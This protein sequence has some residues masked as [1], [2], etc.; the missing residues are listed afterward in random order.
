MVTKD[1]E[2]DKL[3]H[4]LD[5]NDPDA[6]GTVV[7]DE[8]HSETCPCDSCAEVEARYQKLREKHRD[9]RTDEERVDAIYAAIEEAK[10]RREKALDHEAWL[11]VDRLLGEAELE[12]A[13]RVERDYQEFLR[14]DDP[15]EWLL[16]RER[17]LKDRELARRER[18]QDAYD[19]EATEPTAGLTFADFV[20]EV[21]LQDVEKLPSVLCATTA[22]RC[23]MRVW[24][25]PSSANRLRASPGSRSWPL[26]NSYGPVG[27]CSGGTMRT[28]PPRSRDV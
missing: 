27:A 10:E 11:V 16:N 23:S 5:I 28:G 2:L 17:A 1:E 9:T 19:A 7:G 22:K 12:Q 15:D 3:P 6:E 21:T 20:Q 26:S 13:A 24:R 14:K 18:R 4:L 8:L 25:I